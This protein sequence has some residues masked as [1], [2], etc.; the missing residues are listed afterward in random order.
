MSFRNGTSIGAGG[1]HVWWAVPQN[2]IAPPHPPLDF[3]GT[4]FQPFCFLS[5]FLFVC[6]GE[7][8]LLAL[9]PILFFYSLV[10]SPPVLNTAPPTRWAII[11]LTILFLFLLFRATPMAYGGSQ[12]R[13]RIRAAAAGLHHS[14][15]NAN[16]SC[17]CNLHHSS[18]QHQI[19]NPLSE[20]RD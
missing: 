2:A 9:R 6:F 1:M 13:G 7:S 18:R 19:L 20:A 15:S 4:S 12:T 11:N 5:I 16:P 10:S 8:A 17:V 3:Q 14:H